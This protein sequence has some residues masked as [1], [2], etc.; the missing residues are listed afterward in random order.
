MTEPNLG[1]QIAAAAAHH[2]LRVPT[3]FQRWVGEVVFCSPAHI[4]VG[5]KA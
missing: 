1:A 5:C 2:E 4:V 3:L